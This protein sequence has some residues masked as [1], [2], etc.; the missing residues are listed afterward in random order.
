MAVVFRGHDLL[1]DMPIAIKLL[2]QSHSKPVDLKRFLREAR[3][4]A[5][6]VHQNIISI[7]SVLKEEDQLFI[8]MEFVEGEDLSRYIRRAK[9]FPL[10]PVP[11]IKKIFREIVDGLGHAHEYEVVHRDLKPANIMLTKRGRVKLADFG[12]AREITGERITVTGTVVGTPEYMS[13]EQLKCN[14][15][16]L[17]TDIYSLGITF[18]EIIAG[19]TPFMDP[20]KTKIA[21]Y[22]LMNRHMV[23]P[24]PSLVGLG[25]DIPPALDEIILKC[26]AKE[27]DDRYRSCEQLKMAMDRAFHTGAI[28][29]IHAKTQE[30][31]EIPMEMQA[32]ARLVSSE[33]EEEEQQDDGKS[34]RDITVPKAPPKEEAPKKANP[35]KTE[36]MPT[37]DGELPTH[38]PDRIQ[39]SIKKVHL[40]LTMAL[41]FVA[42][43]AFLIS[44]GKKK[45][46]KPTPKRK[47]VVRTET[48]EVEPP[49]PP[50]Q[51]RVRKRPALRP[52]KRPPV[53]ERRP[54]V[55]PPAPEIPDARSA[56][57]IPKRLKARFLR[58]R[59]RWKNDMV[60]IQGGCF[61]QGKNYPG[62]GRRPDYS[63][64]RQICLKSF[65]MDRF[66]VS[67][68]R[69]IDCI[70]SKKCNKLWK[71]YRGRP[72]EM[73]QR[74]LLD[75]PV[76]FVNW[77][78]AKKFCKWAGKRLPTEAEWEYA[79]RG[80]TGNE[81][82][83]GNQNPDCDRSQYRPCS[84]RKR[85]R[86]KIIGLN[87]RKT[88]V[89]PFGIYD[90]AG[91][92][93]EWTRDCYIRDAYKTLRNPVRKYK[94][95]RFSMRGGSW[96]S[97]THEITTYHRKIGYRKQRNSD[98]GFRCVW[99]P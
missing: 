59:I 16:D 26:L 18:F 69:Y 7:R 2:R 89:S 99:R 83:W 64:Q 88:G 51:P 9:E 20:G 10:F 78:D 90:L 79:A 98:F 57:A 66:E 84:S 44:S 67:T 8:V 97:K 55:K 63:P 85:G 93:W 53:P 49:P 43:G 86:P 19:R 28:A 96:R 87:Y 31:I 91:N 73:S 35:L 76:R 27:P 3:T 60:F 34:T 15:V 54:D 32:T 50:I 41:L 37:F 45:T 92:V 1:L 94:C 81:F 52:I 68:N 72:Y 46:P 11:K 29:N 13:P 65:W 39:L 42:I 77:L 58:G 75:R 48:R 25:F 6:L 71:R 23:R 47:Q 24:P 80:M 17:R 33:V 14:P 95:K 61:N 36:V 12:I 4:Q 30:S 74:L 62:T 40:G 22:E 21:L 38:P 82:P 56:P 70:K 5:K